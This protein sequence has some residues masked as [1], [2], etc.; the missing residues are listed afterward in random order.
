MVQRLELRPPSGRRLQVTLPDEPR[1]TSVSTYAQFAGGAFSR[2]FQTGARGY[3]D[4]ANRELVPAT[5]RDRFMVQHR[6]V[7]VA[8]SA[9]GDVTTATWLG[10][11]HE[12][13][14]VFTGPPPSR[15]VIM[16]MFEQFVLD[17]RI[18]GLRVTPVRLSGIQLVSEGLTVVV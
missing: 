4:V 12:M 15:S 10:P 17:D 7:V 11:Y 8:T 18:A 9:D 5:V 6:E 14:T 3:H 13:M 1:V 2:M 16:S